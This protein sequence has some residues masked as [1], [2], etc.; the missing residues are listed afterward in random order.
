MAT[1]KKPA[2]KKAAK[3]ATKKAAKAGPA[4]ITLAGA[5]PKLHLSMPLDKKKIAAI[6]RCIEKG[7]LNVT[8]SKVDLAAGK[9]G[10]AST[11]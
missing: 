8:L 5:I 3:K 7:T 11:H 6:Q 10:S 4:S 1:T 2:A 9:L